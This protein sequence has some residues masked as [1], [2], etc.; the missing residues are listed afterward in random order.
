MFDPAT[1]RTM[2]ALKDITIGDHSITCCCDVCVAVEDALAHIEHLDKELAKARQLI[3]EYDA[4]V[5]RNELIAGG[6]GD[7]F[8][9]PGEQ[10]PWK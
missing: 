5:I 10:M 1:A 6:E 3:A 7:L 9:G 4:R 2:K 8:A